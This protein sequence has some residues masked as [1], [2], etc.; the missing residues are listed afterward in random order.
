MSAEESQQYDAW[1]S[2]AV[3]EL[4]ACFDNFEFV[5]LNSLCRWY[6]MDNRIAVPFLKWLYNYHLDMELFIAIVNKDKTNCDFEPLI[7]VYVDMFFKKQHFNKIK[8]K[9]G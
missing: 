2:N 8:S 5:K 7:S 4:T 1:K 3:K 6:L 9:R